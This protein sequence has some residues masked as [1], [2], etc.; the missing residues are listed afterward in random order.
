VL[1][2]AACLA[3]GVA[4]GCTAGARDSSGEA[5]PSSPRAAREAAGGWT[6]YVLTSS[7]GE[8]T[9]CVG[10]PNAEI[11]RSG[12]IPG[13]RVPIPRGTPPIRGPVLTR[14]IVLE[15]NDDEG[16]GVLSAPAIAPGGV[17]VHFSAIEM[18]GY[19][20][21]AP[22]RAVRAGVIG[23]LPYA[24]EGYRYEATSVRPLP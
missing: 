3:G 16:W 6:T 23:P 21:L 13:V 14:A 7:D 15:W 1:L 10:G 20:S 4:A 8:T 22:G 19:R 24:Q 5:A 9:T 18:K 17:W 12:P 2:L 11:C